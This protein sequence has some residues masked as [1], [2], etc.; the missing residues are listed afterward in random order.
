MGREYINSLKNNISDYYINKNDLTRAQEI[1]NSE[2]YSPIFKPFLVHPEEEPNTEKI[3]DMLLDIMYDLTIINSE[4]GFAGHSFKGLLENTNTRINQIKKDA[5][6]AI[7]RMQ[8]INML[9]S[10]YNSDNVNSLS[11]D[12]FSGEFE[13]EDGLFFAKRNKKE[14]NIKYN[15]IS[16]TGNGY[17]GNKY[18]YTEDNSFLIDKIDTSNRQALS[19]NSIISTYEYSRIVANNSEKDFFPEVNFDSVHAMCTIVLSS[20]D[21][22]SKANIKTDTFVE[23]LEAHVSEDGIM[24]KNIL[25][26]PIILNDEDQK[27]LNAEYVGNYGVISFPSTKYLK[28]LFRSNYVPKEIIAF[29]QNEI[30][31]TIK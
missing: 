6:V 24:F 10:V 17:E 8:D 5:N 9:C 29:N 30:K 11:A 27:Y 22:F 19:D 25:N 18:V 23:L 7:E 20:K 4:L 26:K 12:D 2:L 31:T 21:Y 15:I 14:E 1:S 28:L 13:H 3:K 16:I